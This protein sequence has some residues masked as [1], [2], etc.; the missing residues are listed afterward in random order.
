M[1]I[2]LLKFPLR[3]FLQFPFSGFVGFIDGLGQSNF[4]LRCMTV[5][6]SSQRQTL[7]ISF[8]ENKSLHYPYENVTIFCEP[9]WYSATIG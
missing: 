1:A 6:Q 3:E 4:V 9:S 8:P 2:G 7:P 5:F